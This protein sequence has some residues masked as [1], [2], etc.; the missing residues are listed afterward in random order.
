M[1]MGGKLGGMTDHYLVEGRLRVDGKWRRRRR[2]GREVL[3]MSV[4]NDKEKEHEYQKRLR[5]VWNEVKKRGE[6]GV[7]EEWNRFKGKGLKTA[8]VCEREEW[9]EAEEK[10]VNGGMKR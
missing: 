8:E 1:F 10:I 3:K 7:E 9:V 4:L 5:K 6:D 2:G